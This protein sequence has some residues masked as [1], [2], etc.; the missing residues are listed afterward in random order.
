MK[1]SPSVILMML[2]IFNITDTNLKTNNVDVDPTNFECH[3]GD[4]CLSFR[5]L[6]DGIRD[7]KDGSDENGCGE[8]R[9]YHDAEVRITILNGD[10]RHIETE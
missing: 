10:S 4:D 6:C 7:C 2:L 8:D 3:S 5:Y 1:K 9:S